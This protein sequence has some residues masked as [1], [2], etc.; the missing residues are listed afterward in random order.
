[1][2]IE[3]VIGRRIAQ[4]REEFEGRKMTQ[5]DLAVRMSVL[6]D[7]SWSPTAVSKA[8]NGHRKFTAEELLALS[9][10]FK[11]PIEWFFTLPKGERTVELPGGVWY[12]P[13]LS[14]LKVTRQV[15]QEVQQT[16]EEE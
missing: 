13:D 14:M 11:R 3:R 4:A 15:F 7:L 12:P 5:W 1:M 8:E 10:T 16:E 9:L 2:R 6:V